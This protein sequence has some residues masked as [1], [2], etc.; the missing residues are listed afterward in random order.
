MYKGK[1]ILG[2]IPA[3]GGSK[4]LPGKNI[5]PLQGKPLVAWSIES[6]LQTG[7]LDELLVTTDDEEIGA[8]AKKFGASVPFLRPEELASDSAGTMEVLLHALSYY[9][10]A[11]CSFDLLIL[12]QP[13][14]PLRTAEDILNGVDVFFDKNAGAVI[15]VCEVDHHLDW[16]NKL[17]ENG[18]MKDFVK[19]EAHNIP[20]QQ[21]DKYYRLNGALYVA[22]VKL[23]ELKKS[24]FTENTF[25]YVMKR[26][27][28]V[29][30]DELVDFQI[31][32]FLLKTNLSV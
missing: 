25:A 23:L 9:E 1:K 2:V 28:S 30:I 24:F 22:D 18:C 7:I 11:G 3:R 4:G 15:S 12:L 20:R 16:M 21:L 19:K 10:K 13:T 29:D 8:I 14:S 26:E 31:A 17:P 5:R 6:G 32:D 27:R